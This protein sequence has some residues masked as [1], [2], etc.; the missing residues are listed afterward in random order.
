MHGLMCGLPESLHNSID[1]LPEYIKQGQSQMVADALQK[2]YGFLQADMVT[3]PISYKTLPELLQIIEASG[4]LAL[5]TDL[6]E[7]LPNTE[8]VSDF[9]FN[10]S[11]Q[12]W[13]A[14]FAKGVWAQQEF[15]DRG[16]VMMPL[17]ESGYHMHSAFRHGTEIAGSEVVDYIV[18]P[19]GIKQEKEFSEYVEQ[20]VQH[21]KKQGKP[22]YLNVLFSGKDAIQCLKVLAA[23]SYF[24]NIPLLV[25][26]HMSSPEMLELVKGE[27]LTLHS[28]SMW[29]FES[30]EKENK[31]FREKYIARTGTMANVFS[32]LGYESGLIIG[33]IYP[34]LKS[35]LY[36]EARKLLKNEQIRTPRGERN[37]YL[38]SGYKLPEIDIEKIQSGDQHISRMVIGQGQAM[39]FNHQVFREIHE[40][41]VTGWKNPYLCI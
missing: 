22:S 26:P 34:H 29:N 4:K 8:I 5:F 25:S 20:L 16:A 2:L 1:F 6:G 12:Y 37:F 24:N 38:D 17:Y 14:E 35:K 33:I 32:L 40:E 30:T 18:I 9:V 21:F 11:F 39:P 7:Y 23:N 13:Q 27:Q 10:N 36:A 31:V 28:A 3:G 19:H 15:G 41:S